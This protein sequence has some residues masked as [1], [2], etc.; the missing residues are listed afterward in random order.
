MAPR[1]QSA[2]RRR[3]PPLAGSRPAR[4]ARLAAAVLS[5]L[6]LVALPLLLTACSSGQR[7]KIGRELRKF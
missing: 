1:Q 5:G 7:L 2:R 4:S 6:L 3:R